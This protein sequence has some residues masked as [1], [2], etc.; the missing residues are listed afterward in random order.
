MQAEIAWRAEAEHLITLY[1]FE[2][3]GALVSR[4]SDAVRLCD[5]Q[6]VRKLDHMLQ[7]VEARLEGSWRLPAVQLV[8]PGNVDALAPQ[9][10]L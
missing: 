3:I 9:A 6:A 7:L 1:G 4:I 5:D 2:A 8:E 10:A